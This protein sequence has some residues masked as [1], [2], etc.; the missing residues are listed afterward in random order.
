MKIMT[1]DIEGFFT[2][3]T[4]LGEKKV[5]AVRVAGENTDNGQP[6]VIALTDDGDVLTGHD[7]KSAIVMAQKTLEQLGYKTIEASYYIDYLAFRDYDLQIPEGEMN[8]TGKS[9]REIDRIKRG[10]AINMN[11]DAYYIDNYNVHSTWKA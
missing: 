10:M 8:V 5:T 1:N 2:A 6:M 4:T 7:A 11:H 3:L 9:V